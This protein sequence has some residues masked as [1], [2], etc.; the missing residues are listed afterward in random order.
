MSLFRDSW[1]VWRRKVNEALGGLVEPVKAE[2][3]T[4]DNTDSGLTA[5]DVQSAIDEVANKEPELNYYVGSISSAVTLQNNSFASVVS[6]EL[7]AGFY[8][9]HGYVR[10]VANGTGFRKINI[11]TTDSWAGNVDIANAIA[12]DNTAL[13]T[14]TWISLDA[15]A[16]VYL[17]AFQ[18]SGGELDVNVARLI[19]MKL[20]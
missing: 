17:N 9:L 6:I 1:E 12:N 14:W 8:Y 16:T 18:T 11:S 7:P 20:H 10:Y 5:T 15:P 4:Y 3:V 13:N 2:D 19:A